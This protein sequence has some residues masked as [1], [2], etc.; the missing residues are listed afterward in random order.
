[1]AENYCRIVDIEEETQGE[2]VANKD[3]YELIHSVDYPFFEDSRTK[4]QK[5]KD[6]ADYHINRMRYYEE[7]YF[8]LEQDR[9]EIPLAVILNYCYAFETTEDEL[10]SIVKEKYTFIDESDLIILDP[11]PDE[12][13]SDEQSETNE[14]K[15]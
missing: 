8:V 7:K 10:R 1:M 9:F 15:N 11:I 12:S 4:L 3:D 13:D 14:D 6:E 5:L 2:L